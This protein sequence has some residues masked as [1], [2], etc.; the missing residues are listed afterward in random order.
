M[1]THFNFIIQYIADL[2]GFTIK[3]TI[4]E[5]TMWLFL[6]VFCTKYFKKPFLKSIQFISQRY[7]KSEYIKSLLTSENTHTNSNSQDAFVKTAF[8]LLPLLVMNLISSHLLKVYTVATPNINGLSIALSNIQ[9]KSQIASEV[10]IFN[11]VVFVFNCLFSAILVSKFLKHTVNYLSNKDKYKNKP[12]HSLS[13]ISYIVFVVFLIVFVYVHF[14]NQPP[15]NL[16]TTLSVVSVAIFLTLK[17]VIMGIVST[18]LII[19][20]NIVQVGDWIKNEKYHADGK[21]IEINLISV[22]I[23]N[24]DKTIV[25]IPTYSLI[26]EG[27]MNRQ[28]MLNSDLRRIKQVIRID[29]ESIKHIGMAE[30]ERL[31]QIKLLEG[32]IGKKIN[33]L[34]QKG[35]SENE[36]ASLNDQYATNLGLFRKYMLKYIEKNPMIFNIKNKTNKSRRNRQ[37]IIDG[38]EGEILVR[39]IEGTKEGVGLEIYCFSNSSDWRTYEYLIAKLLEHMYATAHHFDLKVNC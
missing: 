18:I 22:K 11:N 36:F 12:L 35:D 33:E 20:N 10:L 5:I 31:Q 1:E 15:K 39:I 3:E 17:D 24:F 25:T 6:I 9:T 16:F 8:Y 7:I 34:N 4:L 26:S 21:I 19:S 28:E 27:F 32:Y 14:T 30:L 29:P 38:K 37:N 23:L 2:T 13:Q